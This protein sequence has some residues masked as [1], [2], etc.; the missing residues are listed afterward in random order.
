MLNQGFTSFDDPKKISDAQF[1][2]H[3]PEIQY[4]KIENEINNK[5]DCGI[6]AFEIQFILSYI[7]ANNNNSVKNDVFDVKKLCA[8]KI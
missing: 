1:N 5:I 3:C 2:S 4:V 8:H 7:S 6:L